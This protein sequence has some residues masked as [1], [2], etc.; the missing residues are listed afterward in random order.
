MLFQLPPAEIQ[1]HLLRQ[2]T[3]DLQALSSLVCLSAYTIH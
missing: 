1:S 3:P 2:P